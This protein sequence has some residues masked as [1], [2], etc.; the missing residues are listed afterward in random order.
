MLPL[1]I[2]GAIAA[3]PVAAA[4]L[5]R[6][7]SMLLFTSVAVG[8]LLVRYLGEEGALVV[9]GF[10]KST[11]ATMVA[12][13]ALLFLPVVLTLLFGHH[14]LSKTKAVLHFVPIIATGAVIALLAL[15]LLPNSFQ[16][17]VY[18]SP[19]GNDIRQLQNLAIA[20]AGVA[21]L[22]VAWITNS[23]KGRLGK[24]H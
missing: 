6:V 14:S 2:L 1:V 11:N 4:I 24:R 20:A 18:S 16:A 21:S 22:L 10:Y 15:T 17:A 5:W 12:Q 3:V 13:L 7:N 8:D 9:A 19:F 23:T